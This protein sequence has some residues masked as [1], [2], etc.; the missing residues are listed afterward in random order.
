M[1]RSFTINNRLGVEKKRGRG[2][3]EG[4][5]EAEE[6]GQGGGRGERMG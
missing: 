1:L 5:R 6:R 2:D 4:K 3:R